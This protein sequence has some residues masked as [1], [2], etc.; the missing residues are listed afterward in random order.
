[1]M[2]SDLA[3][4][5]R[6][7]LR[8]AHEDCRL[9]KLGELWAEDIQEILDLAQEFTQGASGSDEMLTGDEFIKRWSTPE[10]SGPAS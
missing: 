10:I 4:Q 1:M 2:P 9:C 8:L 7:H 6:E 5:I 3:N